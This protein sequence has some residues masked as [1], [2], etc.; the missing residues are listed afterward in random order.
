MAKFKNGEKK[1]T[2]IKLSIMSKSHTY[3]QMMTKEPAKF[4]IDHYKTVWGNAH[5]RYPP[6]VVEYLVEKGGITPQGESR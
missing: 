1:I 3:L 5:T 4:Q 6:S 2:K